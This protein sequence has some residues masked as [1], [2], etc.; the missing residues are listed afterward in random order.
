MRGWIKG[1]GEAGILGGSAL[2]VVSAVFQPPNWQGCV[3][4]GVL[5]FVLGV[6][7]LIYLERFIK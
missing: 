4:A 6:L 3:F 1:A 7:N 5:A 2:V